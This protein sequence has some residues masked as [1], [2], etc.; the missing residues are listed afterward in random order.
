MNRPSQA[1]R[2]TWT[3]SI[4]T[5]FSLVGDA[6]LYAVLPSQYA[7]LGLTAFQVGWLLSVNRLVRIPLNL[8]SGWLSERV[9]PRL[10]YLVGLVL[11]LVS[12]VGYGLGEGLW[13]L[14]AFR[15]LWGVAWALLVVAAYGMILDV[16]TVDTR[17]RLLGTYASVSY[18]GG[19]LGAV[20]GG[21]F[22]DSVG[23]ARATLILGGCTSFGCLGALTLP[24]TREPRLDGGS[25]PT[26]PRQTSLGRLALWAKSLWHCDLRLKVIALLNFAHRFFFA[27]VFYATFGH[28]LLTTLG[29]EVRLGALMVGVA[30][31]TG[32]LLFVRNVLTVL[33]A[34]TL[35]N[36]SDRLGDR[37]RVLL[38]GETLGVAGLACF[39]LGR[40]PWVLGLGVLFAATAYGVVP[41]LLV[42]WMGD[43]TRT[44]ERG[45]LV[46]GYQTMG[47]LGS[48][49]GPLFAYSLLSLVGVRWA[50]GI[51]AGLLS[52]TVPLILTA[53]RNK[54]NQDGPVSTPPG[55]CG[56]GKSRGASRYA[57]ARSKQQY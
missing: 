8:V 23:F 55:A 39:A 17:G 56:C 10:P 57:P 54:H 3:L 15:L 29:Q 41:P 11:G 24:R 26:D 31:L 21:L 22:V 30:S 25:N 27:G 48:G 42:A 51:S 45:P 46:G 13:L 37:H 38:L 9:D 19:A 2:V 47:D 32:T 34:P 53:R 49:I 6:T 43:L 18:F 16:T 14:L 1:L 50:Y 4:C 44:G 20:L 35:G 33:L 12:T 36:L 5:A 40:S 7:F 28:Y 52:L